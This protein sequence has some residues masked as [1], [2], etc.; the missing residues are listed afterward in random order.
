MYR[1]TKMQWHDLEDVK[2]DEQSV[3]LIDWKDTDVFADLVSSLTYHAVTFTAS[4]ERCE[5]YMIRI[6]GNR[7]SNYNRDK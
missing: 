2:K 7:P 1:G 6:V 3:I 4:L 5:N